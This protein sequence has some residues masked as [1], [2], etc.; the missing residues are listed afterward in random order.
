MTTPNLP[1]GGQTGLRSDARW[2]LDEA[3]TLRQMYRAERE[4]REQAE[5]R[6]I[7]LE[8]EQNLN[9]SQSRNGN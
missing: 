6:L 8:R 1:R 3:A 9:G 5:R 7:E 4:K 2:A